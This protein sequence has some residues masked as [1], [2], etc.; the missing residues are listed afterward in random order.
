MYC[1]MLSWPMFKM[2]DG[3]NGIWKEEKQWVSCLDTIVKMYALGDRYDLE[4]L[5]KEAAEKFATRLDELFFEAKN[6][7]LLFLSSIPPLRI[8]IAGSVTKLWTMAAYTGER[9]GFNR[10]SKISL[11]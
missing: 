9:S 4:G 5:K 10:G 8:P 11:Q 2:N 6:S 7:S 3:M 1:Y